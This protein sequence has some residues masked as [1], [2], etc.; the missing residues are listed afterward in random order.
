MAGWKMDLLKMYLLH[1]NGDFPA[2]HVSLLEG[3]TQ[4]KKKA[5]ENQLDD[6]VDVSTFRIF[7]LFGPALA[8]EIF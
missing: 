3:K 2:C 1:I 4:R 6:D 8:S 7:F 5:P